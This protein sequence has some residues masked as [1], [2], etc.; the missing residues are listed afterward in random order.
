MALDSACKKVGK[1]QQLS[2]NPLTSV[3]SFKGSGMTRSI[4]KKFAENLVTGTA[5]MAVRYVGSSGASGFWPKTHSKSI[6]NQLER[7]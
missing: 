4:G 7:R 6:Y 5:L 2:D 3:S 1:E